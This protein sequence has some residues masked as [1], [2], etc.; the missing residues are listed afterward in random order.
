MALVADAVGGASVNE[1]NAAEGGS[2]PLPS[3][4]PLFDRVVHC[5]SDASPLFAPIPIVLEVQDGE[6]AQHLG[7]LDTALQVGVVRQAFHAASEHPVEATDHF[8]KS[9][10][11]EYDHVES[12]G[13]SIAPAGPGS[14]RQKLL[15]RRGNRCR[16]VGLGSLALLYLLDLTIEVAHHLEGATFS[17]VLIVDT[18]SCKSRPIRHPKKGE[19]LQR[20]F[21]GSRAATRL[22]PGQNSTVR[23]AGEESAKNVKTERTVPDENGGSGRAGFVLGIVHRS[24]NLSRSYSFS[25]GAI[26]S[27]P[28]G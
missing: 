21:A 26:S 14:G 27:G 28:P 12:Q 13:Q 1:I 11:G 2:S 9:G 4:A 6:E 20:A 23:R 16:E 5:L 8:G 22:F 17:G 10:A 25:S 19:I 3:L 24:S 7:A 18:L 15:G